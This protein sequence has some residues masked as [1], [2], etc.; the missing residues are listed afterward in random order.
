MKLRKTLFS[1]AMARNSARTAL[2]PNA[3][4][5]ASGPRRMA[6]GTAA[7]ISASG[8]P[9]A[10]FS[11]FWGCAAH[12]RHGLALHCAPGARDDRRDVADADGQP[13]QRRV[14]YVE[15]PALPHPA[16]AVRARLQ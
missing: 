6:G 14:G 13:E 7:P 10:Y 9:H 12:C 1:L 8:F 16:R 4:G 3:A 5:M 11:P 15:S 2:S